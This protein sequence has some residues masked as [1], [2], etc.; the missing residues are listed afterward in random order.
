MGAVGCSGAL[1]CTMI[2]HD[3]AGTTTET[4]QRYNQAITFSRAGASGA[5]DYRS[6]GTHEAGH[7]IG[8]THANSSDALTM[9]YAVPAGAMHARSLGKGDVMGCARAPRESRMRA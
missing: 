8:L 3:G 2:W 7:S 6:V 1:A 4:D 9:Y 5:H